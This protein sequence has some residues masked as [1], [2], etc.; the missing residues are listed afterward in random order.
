MSLL[1]KDPEAVLDYE[2]DWG[3]DYLDDDM[4]L[5]S[6]W[7]VTPAEEGGVTVVSDGFEPRSSFVSLGGGAVGHLYRVANIVSTQSGREDKRSLFLRVEA[8]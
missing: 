6:R 8:R 3:A 1:L 7:E 4:L 2:I 5:T